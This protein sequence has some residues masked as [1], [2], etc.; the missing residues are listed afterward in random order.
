M[1]TAAYEKLLE[2]L[3]SAKLIL[4]ANAG[5]LSPADL[6]VRCLVNI[7]TKEAQRSL[8]EVLARDRAPRPN[9]AARQDG[10]FTVHATPPAATLQ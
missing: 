4:A 2:I 6:R 1:D 9:P 10:A 3:A 5:S 7:A 8:L